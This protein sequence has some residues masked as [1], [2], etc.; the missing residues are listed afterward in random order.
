MGAVRLFLALVV[1]FDHVR[2]FILRPANVDVDVV[3][4]LGFNAGYAVMFFYIISGFLISFV[5]RHKY[6][7]SVSGTR[8]F[9]KSRFIRIFSLYWPLVLITLV[10]VQE[11]REM[12]LQSS[13][14]DKLTSTFLIGIDWNTAFAHYPARNA[15]AAIKW[16]DQAWSLGAELGF[17]LLAPFI[18]RS[19][20][21]TLG[22][23]A[24][25]AAIRVVTVSAFGFSEAWTYQFLPS[26]MVFFLLGHLVGVASDRVAVLRLPV[27]GVLLAVACVLSLMFPTYAGWDTPRFWLAVVCFGLALPGL[28]EGTKNNTLLNMLG[29]LS[30]PVYLVHL[31]IIHGL[32][33]AGY[34]KAVFAGFGMSMPSCYLI[35]GSVV[36]LSVV[37]AMLAHRFIERPFASLLHAAFRL[38]SRGERGAMSPE[39]IPPG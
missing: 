16:L 7:A 38:R 12:F 22:V 11:S 19:H 37:V 1:V 21:L 20:R 24:V 25:S 15:N 3:Y 10:S 9:Y 27:A 32:E 4:A 23:L 28:F 33:Q 34:F 39:A 35:V 26:T 31:L 14:T 8:A 17:Y 13:L 30:F 29:D 5:L 2:A 18:L 6:P 36:S